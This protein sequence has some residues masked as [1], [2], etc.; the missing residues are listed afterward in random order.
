MSARKYILSGECR[1]TNDECWAFGG[2]SFAIRHSTFGIRHSP[3]ATRHSALGILLIFLS[4]LGPSTSAGQAWTLPKGTAYVKTSYGSATAAQ[5]FTFD[6]R[7]T[8]YINGLPGDTYRD[9]SLY[10]YSE[11]GLSDNFSAILSVPY[12]RTFVRDHSFRFRIFGL[13]SIAIGGRLSLLPLLAKTPARQSLSVNL[14]AYVPTGYTRNFTPSTGAGQVDFQ[15]TLFWGQSFYPFPGYAQLGLGY[16]HR[17][18]I[19]LLSQSTPCNSGSDIHCITDPQA[20]YG[21]EL[22]FHAEAG[23]SPF[24]GLILLQAIGSGAWALKKPQVGFSAINPL[25]THQRIVKAGAG[26]TLYPFHAA[27]SPATNTSGL[28]TLGFSAQYFQVLYG[29]NTIN[30]RDLFLG[31]ELRPRFF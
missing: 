31:I 26:L 7:A 29:R 6:G 23:I 11:F 1:V 10:L 25:P 21:D 27:K 17:S 19:Y 30:S 18:S 8:D 5:Q 24:N 13:G 12:K 22:L 16:R 20:A 9:R 14:M 3:L 15:G 28:R 4:C 2:L